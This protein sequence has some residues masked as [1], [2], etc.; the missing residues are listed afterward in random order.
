MK[1]QI[2]LLQKQC[3]VPL[4]CVKANSFLGKQS[5]LNNG[6]SSQIYHNICKYITCIMQHYTVIKMCTFKEWLMTWENVYNVM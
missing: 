6:N 2:F 5:A 1:C 3:Q 4:P